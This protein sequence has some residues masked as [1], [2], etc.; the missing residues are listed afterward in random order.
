M[1]LV[2]IRGMGMSCVWDSERGFEEHSWRYTTLISDMKVKK[3]FIELNIEQNS[4]IDLFDVSDGKT[5]MV[6]YL[7]NS[8]N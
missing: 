2:I 8:A 5:T 1:E 7:E 6:E 3:L 4:G